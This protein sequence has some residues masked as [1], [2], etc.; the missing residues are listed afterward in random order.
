MSVYSAAEDD[1]GFLQKRVAYPGAPSPEEHFKAPV[2]EAGT[3]YTVNELVRATLQNSDNNAAYLL[4]GLLGMESLDKSYSRLGIETPTSGQ[5]YTTTVRSY[6][7][8]FRVLYTA[9]YLDRNA[10]EELLSILSETVFT[11]GIVAGV[12]K[13]IVVAHKFGERSLEDSSSVQ[14]HDCGI[15]YAPGNPYLLC[16][17]MRGYDFDTLANSIAAVSSLVY[18]YAN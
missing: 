9:T 17:M 11:Q 3:S 6:A 14:L 10:S 15:V 5:D 4:A 8:F 16:V 7:S 18:S 1:P 12:P 2:I 13:G